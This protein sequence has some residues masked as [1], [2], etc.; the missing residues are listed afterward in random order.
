MSTHNAQQKEYF[1]T[2]DG[3]KCKC[4]YCS[5][6]FVW[7]PKDLQCPTCKKTVKPP[8]GYFKGDKQ[9]Q[10]KALKR[11]ELEQTKQLR[12]I[13]NRHEFTPSRKPS[14]LIFIV[15]GLF[16]L[17]G[18]VV[19]VTQKS[20]IPEKRRK[21]NKLELTLSDIDI[22]TKALKHYQ[23]DTGKYPSYKDG[24]LLALISN[25]GEVNWNGPYINVI[26]NDGWNR[27]Y[28]YDRTNGV[29]VLLS[30]G[31]DKEYLTDDDIYATPEQYVAHPDFVPLT[32]MKQRRKQTLED[33]SVI[34][35]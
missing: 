12:K 24:G 21:A 10:R 30:A 5:N 25:P 8:F 35:K 11:I 26:H 31:P 20:T 19:S 1:P 3:K 18:A 32:E 9:E 14:V 16:V 28:H 6:T 17:G 7:P 2:I 29:P 34:I 22:Y 13:G 15:M 33:I 27:P 4:P 23:I